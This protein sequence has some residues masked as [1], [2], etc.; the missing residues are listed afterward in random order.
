MLDES[1]HTESIQQQ[2][3]W[4]VL[5]LVGIKNGHTSY[6]MLLSLLYFTEFRWSISKDRN[7]AEDGIDLRRRFLLDTG[8]AQYES[9]EIWEDDPCSVL[10]MMVALSLRCEN[11]IMADQDAGDRAGQWFMEMLKSLG[12]ACMTD[13]HFDKQ[14]TINII[15][16]FLNRD[17]LRNG[18]GGLFT[19][20]SER[21][22]MRSID[23]WYQMMH[24]LSETFYERG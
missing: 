6:S 22:D 8:I 16:R 11:Q 24:W 4:W 12:L 13:E 10:E 9:I 2:Y 21:W 23:I 7:R 14:E 20:C 1:I 19:I 17:Y 18:H 3:Y 5:G 15:N